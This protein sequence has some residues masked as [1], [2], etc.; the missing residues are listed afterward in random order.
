MWKS[1]AAL[2]IWLGSLAGLD[3]REQKTARQDEEAAASVAVFAAEET[4]SLQVKIDSLRA[5]VE[6]IKHGKVGMDRGAR[7]SSRVRQR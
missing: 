4:E 2:C 1:A 7:R 3:R 6:R 5:E